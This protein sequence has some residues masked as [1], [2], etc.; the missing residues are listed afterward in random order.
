MLQYLPEHGTRVIVA[1]SVANFS[2]RFDKETRTKSG[3]RLKAHSE[4]AEDGKEVF[5][6]AAGDQAV[7]TLVD[8]WEDVVFG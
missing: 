8:G 4:T 1:Q 3:V 5:F 6:A 2:R 7:D